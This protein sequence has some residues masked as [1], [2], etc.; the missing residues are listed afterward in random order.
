MHFRQLLQSMVSHVSIL[1]FLTGVSLQA[2]D[3][4]WN[5]ASTGTQAWSLNTNWAG[6][7]IP[8]A[9]SGTTNTD[10]ATFGTTTAATA[11][12]IDAG[13]NIRSMLFNGTN[14]AGLYTIGSDGANAG[15]ALNLTSGGN[16]TVAA[17]TQTIT[18]I[19]APLIIQ[20]VSATT[21][22][23]YTL[24]NNA[25]DAQMDPN[26]FKLNVAGNIS[27]GTTNSTIT[28]NLT[29]TAGSRNVDTA[30]NTISGLIS[31]G[32]AAG[33]LS[34]SVTGSNGGD[35]GAWALTNVNNSFTGNVTVTSGTLLFSS[36]ADSGINSALGA[37]NTLTMV[38]GAQVK[39]TGPAASTNR[40]IT[41][42]GSLFSQGT[43]ALTLTG[44]FLPV[45]T[46]TFR[47]SQ[48]FIIE[49]VIGGT[50]SLNR[51]DPGTV[52]L[53]NVNTFTGN[54]S[55]QDG[56]YRFATLADKNLPSGIGAGT[57]ITLGQN[58]NT[59]GRI[60][61]TGASG[62]SSNRDI[63]LNNGA[64]AASSGNGRINN[65]VAGQTLT[66]SG[67]VKSS[68]A[69]ATF[70]SSLDL[71]GVGNGVMSG[72]IGGTSSNASATIALQLLKTGTG[73]WALSGANNYSRGTLISGGTLLATNTTGSATGIGNVITSG[74]GTTLGGTGIITGGAGSSITIASGTRL[75]IGNTHQTAA[76]A[77]GNAGYI[78]GI[79]NLRLGTNASV[80]IT[81]AGTLQFDLFSNAGAAALGQADLLTLSTTSTT[82]T[83]GGIIS[84]ADVTTAHAGWREGQW[85]LI[86]WTGTTSATKSGTFTFDLPT[87]ALAAGYEWNTTDFLTTG[88]ISIQKSINHTWLGTI[89]NSWGTAANWEIGTVPTSSNDV[90]FSNATN[91]L[92]TAINGDRSVR[93]LYFTGDNNFT[94]NTG[95]GGV[96]YSYG[97]L[98]E[99][100]GGTQTIGAQ[101]RIANGT[102]A[103]YT[104]YNDGTLNM[105]SA[106][107]MWHRLSGSGTLLNIVFDG[108][109]STSVN[110]FQRR[111]NTYDVNIVKNGTG[112]L[113]LS[114]NTTTE[115][116][117][118]A[119]GS[120]TGSTT[121]NAGK[122]RI[123]NEAN[124][125]TNPAAFN[126]AHLTLNGGTL[127]AY[128]DVVMDD[129]NRGITVGTNGGSIEVEPTR[130]FT[131][132][133]PIAGSGTLRKTGTGTLI[134]SNG[135]TTHS[136]TTEVLAGSLQ[137][138]ATGVTGT[139][140]MS[141]SY[142]AQLTGTGLV[143]S[144]SFSVLEG[145]TVAPGDITSGFIT[146]NG[147]LT[148][149]PQTT[150]TYEFT[151]SSTLLLSI[152]SA[153]NQGV[154]DP[155]FGGNAVGSAGYNAFV[156]A[157]TGAG[158]H[159]RVVFNGSTGTSLTLAGNI[160]VEGLGFI[161]SAGQVFNL[162][163]WSTLVSTNFSGFDVGSNRNG[164]G[165]NGTQFD[166]PDISA[167]GYY[168][169]VSRFLTSGVIVVV[170]PEPSRALLMGLGLMLLFARRRRQNQA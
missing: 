34:V 102:S 114:G 21:A 66:L 135:S 19:N 82:I 72:V 17:G 100:L 28:L 58:S 157:V 123:N 53:N 143:Q 55:A 8:G 88:I 83:L 130:T 105:S 62:G 68:N 46:I 40:T 165:D 33:G 61:F 81:L 7:V 134:L 57:T 36:I 132:A 78:G 86:D 3:S 167:F 120:I 2:A 152:T 99:V 162:L 32:G 124:L 108:S 64:D 97:S 44:T 147:T 60:E 15:P 139:G 169:D 18:T 141:V 95:T 45:G 150:G 133:T 14:T 116:T 142:G 136:G 41:G 69:T 148:F 74:A 144:S 128:A 170:I 51:T 52:F 67:T 24:T 137:V 91:N 160:K 131:V 168:W 20:P 23:V 159:D 153:T 77:T 166:L 110:H 161:P 12:T 87:T 94:I 154:L 38:S 76:G 26:A 122:I 56:A 30:G 70:L 107:V 29:G 115:A 31:N 9:T 93:N 98:L 89:D 22:G 1:S 54:V 80:S 50:G 129:A 106:A 163:D 10:L 121:I 92:M 4:S 37:G 48:N 39:Y 11:I 111:A 140:A 90:F 113:T 27:G 75:M 146:G 104:I 126:A 71:T 158:N 103:N 127:A 73:T 43:G 151:T 25:T 112:T 65:T 117:A 79:S 138:G 42:S 125:G 96:L 149:T 118:S 84:V 85:Q 155:T 13:R 47:G 119:A 6:S 16:I 101:L 63:I 35:R 59:V 145:G 5:P 109:G 156:D 164:A 49:S